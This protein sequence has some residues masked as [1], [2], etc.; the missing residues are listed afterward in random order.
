MHKRCNVIIPFALIRDSP[1]CQRPLSSSRD[2]MGGPLRSAAK[3]ATQFVIALVGAFFICSNTQAVN[4]T[5]A[6]P[7]RS[8]MPL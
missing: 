8:S 1:S 7:Y 3:P 5:L 6:F 2:S 4:G